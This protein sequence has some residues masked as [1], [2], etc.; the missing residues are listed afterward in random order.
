MSGLADSGGPST[1]CSLNA[2]HVALERRA[3]KKNNKKSLFQDIWNM[4][5]RSRCRFRENRL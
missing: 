2:T 1:E 3:F 4:K 5:P